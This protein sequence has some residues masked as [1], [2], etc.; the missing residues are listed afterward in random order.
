MPVTP[1]AQWMS[2]FTPAITPAPELATSV[3]TIKSCNQST[4]KS[5]NE[6]ASFGR[7]TRASAQAHQI[8]Q[9]M[10]AAQVTD[11]IPEVPP[12]STLQPDQAERVKCAF[13]ALQ[14]FCLRNGSTM[15]RETMSNQITSLYSK[16]QQG[17]IEQ[18]LQQTLMHITVAIE[19]NDYAAAYQRL[20]EFASCNE[21]SKEQWL[22]SVK[23]LL[24][25]A[26]DRQAVLAQVTSK[27]PEVQP[28]QVSGPRCRASIYE[29]ASALELQ[30]AKKVLDSLF[31]ASSRDWNTNKREHT[32]KHL[33]EL[34][35]Q[36]Q[37]GQ[38]RR[39]TQQQVMAAVHAVNGGKFPEAGKILAELSATCWKQNK[40]WLPGVQRLISE[41]KLLK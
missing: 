16:L 29:P 32:R 3:E 41:Q 6:S 34:F 13:D 33:D 39:Q 1:L 17:C 28:V 23:S 8:Y 36:L 7:S 11:K 19:L 14:G 26:V 15:W 30:H 35:F 22:H 9:Q 37:T 2:K 18:P 10:V 38:L 25:A 24:R 21:A 27:A 12:E 31:V 4:V 5:A 40:Q 20:E